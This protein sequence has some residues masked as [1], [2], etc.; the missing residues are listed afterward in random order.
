MLRS[1]EEIK[2]DIEDRLSRDTRI[3]NGKIKI[4]VHQGKVILYG[5]VQ[6][7]SARE[8][9]EADTWRVLGVGAIENRLD[10]QF[11]DGYRRPSDEA[12]RESV[13]R[14]LSWDPDL[15]LE[16]IGV[17]VQDGKVYLEG[18][19]DALWKKIRARQLAFNAGGVSDVINK[20]VVSL[21]SKISDEIIGKEIMSLLRRNSSTNINTINIEVTNNK[22]ILSGSVPDRTAFDVAEDI[23]RY[24][25]GVADV[26]NRLSISV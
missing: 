21:T 26:E 25:Q 23:A 3:E 7:Y 11:R 10:V 12:I 5:T 22:V 20:L 8:A 14:L 6:S 4:D 24:V 18:A 16:R 17:F 2:M 19:V 1:T 15:F 9:A 13:E